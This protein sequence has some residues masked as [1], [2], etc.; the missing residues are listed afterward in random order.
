MDH[1]KS[2]IKEEKMA[3]FLRPVA[4]FCAFSSDS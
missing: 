2:R 1:E 3:K 4:T